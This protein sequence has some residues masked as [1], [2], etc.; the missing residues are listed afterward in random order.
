M[1]LARSF[2]DREGFKGLMMLFC[3]LVMVAANS[4]IL[5]WLGVIAGQLVNSNCGSFAQVLNASLSVFIILQIDDEV[6]PFVRF[7]AEERGYLSRT[8]DLH[9]EQLNRLTFGN[10]YY[11]PGYAHYALNNAMLGGKERNII[12]RILA[13]ILSCVTIAIVVIPAAVTI[14]EAS[15]SFARCP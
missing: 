7:W 8:G 15:A 11:K 9:S 5:A 14:A 10:Q 12:L 4:A 3:N 1:P 2:P 13:V 6:L